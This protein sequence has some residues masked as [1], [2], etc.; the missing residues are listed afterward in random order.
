MVQSRW[1]YVSI[2]TRA[3]IGIM[4]AKSYA[5][6]TATD[7]TVYFDNFANP[8]IGPVGGSAR[9]RHVDRQDGNDHGF[10][11]QFWTVPGQPEW[12]AVQ[13]EYTRR[14]KS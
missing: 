4:F 2:D 11:E 14:K 1:E 6:D 12:L 10:K 5:A 13:Y 3:P 8:G 9:A 7:V